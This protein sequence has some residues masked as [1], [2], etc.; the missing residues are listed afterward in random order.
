MK[1]IFRKSISVLQEFKK[2]NPWKGRIPVRKEK[3]LWLNN[4]LNKIHSRNIRLK[5]R[6]PSKL[7]KWHASGYSNVNWNS[8]T[9]ILRGR[10]SVITF[11][12]EWGH[13]LLGYSERHAQCFA[14]KLFRKI[15]PKK[16][17][18]LT[19]WRFLVIKGRY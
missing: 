9:I 14:T 15:F 8:Q 10:L 11:L 1:K 6:V 17:K 13:I 16:W 7:N 19:E 4:K 2:K 12:H 5:F 3:F 18:K